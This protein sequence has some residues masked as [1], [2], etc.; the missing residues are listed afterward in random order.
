M[1]ERMGL[2]VLAALSLAA[3]PSFATPAE[4]KSKPRGQRV[5][6]PMSDASIRKPK[7]DSLQRMLRR[8]R[9]R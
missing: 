6:R 3:M 5:K 1:H 8:A 2:G 4:P 9:Q 7:S